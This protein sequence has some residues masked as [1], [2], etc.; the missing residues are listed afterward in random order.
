MAAKSNKDGDG[1]MKATEARK[2]LGCTR[3][4][5]ARLIREGLLP[6]VS[7]P[8]DRRVKLVKRAD[9][10]RLIASSTQRATQ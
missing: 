4:V 10:E 8:L 9:V 1:H 5:L 3:D 2:L 6:T 7:D